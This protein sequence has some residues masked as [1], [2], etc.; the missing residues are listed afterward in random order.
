MIRE[1]LVVDRRRSSSN[2]CI[3]SLGDYLKG[4]LFCDKCLCVI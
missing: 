2:G 3:L 4:S 1:R